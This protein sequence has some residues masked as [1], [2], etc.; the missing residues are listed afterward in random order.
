MGNAISEVDGDLSRTSS[1]CWNQRRSNIGE[2]QEETMTA[3]ERMEAAVKL[4]RPDRV[5]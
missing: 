3:M 2:A 1:T 4:E 5:P